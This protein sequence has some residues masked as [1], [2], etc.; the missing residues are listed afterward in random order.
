MISGMEKQREDGILVI[1]AC[2]VAV[3]RLRGEP[4]ARPTISR[5]RF[6]TQCSLARL[7]L[8]ELQR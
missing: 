7:V 8:R 4:I 5:L 3:I 2:I 1:A 6:Q